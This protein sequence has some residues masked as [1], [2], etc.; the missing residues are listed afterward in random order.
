MITAEQVNNF[1][2]AA[3]IDSK[4]DGLSNGRILIL[5]DELDALRAD[6]ELGALVRGMPVRMMIV[7]YPLYGDPEGDKWVYTDT[8]MVHHV[9]FD[10]QTIDELVK[11][12]KQ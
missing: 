3:E 11:A 7:H 4:R 8:M 9:Y 10:G 1:R 6:A 12:V 2:L 5:C